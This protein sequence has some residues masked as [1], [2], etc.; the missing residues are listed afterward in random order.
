MWWLSVFPCL[1]ACLAAATAAAAGPRLVASA[2]SFDFG[3]I[4]RGTPVDHVFRVRNEGDAPASILGIDRSCAC[5]VGAAS[6]PTVAPGQD[7]W[8]SVGLDTDRLAG[9]VVKA[10]TLR[11]ADPGAAAIRLVVQGTV[12]SDLL[13][14]PPTLYVGEVWRGSEAARTASVR[15]G[16]PAGAV[17][18]LAVRARGPFVVPR[19]IDDGAG[20]LRI[21]VRV[22]DDAP[23][24][25][26]RDEIVVRGG[27]LDAPVIVPVLGVVRTSDDASDR[28]V[29]ARA[30]DTIRR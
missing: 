27:G 23:A 20:G 10:V 21:A 12:L 29:V 9:H 11:S 22:A 16:R 28:A 3:S 2:A 4:E 7:L 15:S 13:A 14:D 6:A 24:G 1:V 17:R 8:V 30:V 19:V 25:R 26:F 5:T 18:V